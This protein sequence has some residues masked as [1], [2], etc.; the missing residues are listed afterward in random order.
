MITPNFQSLR[1]ALHLLGV[2][3][4]IGGQLVLAGIV[5]ALRAHTP[6]ATAVVARGFARL[7]WPMFLL[8]VITGVWGFAEVDPASR[9]SQYV[10]T[11]G[12]KMFLVGA[13]AI[14][15]LVHSQGQSKVAKAVGGALGLITALAAAYLGI[16]LAHVG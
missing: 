4:W 8:V 1:V 6:A 2:S 13:T 12:I 3:V 9:S 14:S 10:A 11:F 16:L 7:A 15:A 5:P